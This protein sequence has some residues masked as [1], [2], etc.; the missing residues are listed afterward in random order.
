M[1]LANVKVDIVV[2]AVRLLRVVVEDALQH[3]VR[4]PGLVETQRRLAVHHAGDDSLTDRRL[5]RYVTKADV[6]LA[7]STSNA[8]GP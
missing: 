6:I 4:D 2:H 1:V 5:G 8:I 3:L 7:A